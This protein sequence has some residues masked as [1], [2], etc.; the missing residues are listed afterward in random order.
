MP[1]PTMLDLARAEAVLGQ[2]GDAKA[3]AS[4]MSRDGVVL[5]PDARRRT[6]VATELVCLMCARPGV[7]GERS[8]QWCGGSL[9]LEAV[10]DVA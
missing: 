5:P 4:Y 10:A 9:V 1:S 8:C 2:T 7:R 3:I 6:V